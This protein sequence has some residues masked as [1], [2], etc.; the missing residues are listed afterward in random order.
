M[1]ENT[2]PSLIE[3]PFKTPYSEGSQSFPSYKPWL[4]AQDP[5]NILFASVQVR[6]EEDEERRGGEGQKKGKGGLSSPNGFFI[7]LPPSPSL[8]S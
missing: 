2:A 5:E 3:V 1:V 4:G 6:R 7:S 8:A